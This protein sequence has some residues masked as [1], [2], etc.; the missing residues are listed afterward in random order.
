MPEVVSLH[1][2]SGR[3]DIV[4]LVH[5]RSPSDMDGVLDRMGTKPGVVRTESAIILSTKLD[6]R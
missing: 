3:Y 6:R 4:A 2:V 5:A 1:T